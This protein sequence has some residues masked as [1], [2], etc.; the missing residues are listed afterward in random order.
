METLYIPTEN[1]FKKWI[2]VAVQE[3]LDGSGGIVL[4]NVTKKNL[5]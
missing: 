5:S 1:D 4:Q 2:K 3:W